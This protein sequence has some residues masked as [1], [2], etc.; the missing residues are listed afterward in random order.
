MR[1]AADENFDGNILKQL[2][3][4]FP[5][6]D[7]VRVQDTE[8][9]QSP[10][11]AVLEWAAKEERIILTHD[12]QTLVGDAYARIEQGL[13]MPGVILIPETLAMGPALAD[14]EVAIGAGVPDD[15]RD[16]ATFIPMN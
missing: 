1:F 5:E 7:I 8:M 2:R 10:D 6:L 13:P 12:V 16:R 14:L 15:F 11:P 3:K 4:R 9:Y